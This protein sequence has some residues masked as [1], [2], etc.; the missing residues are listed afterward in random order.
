MDET[1]LSGVCVSTSDVSNIATNEGWTISSSNRLR[2][3]FFVY[4]VTLPIT[5]TKSF[6]ANATIAANYET[7]KGITSISAVELQQDRERSPQ[8][9]NAVFF[10]GDTELVNVATFRINGRIYSAGNLMVGASKS[11]PITFYQV[12]SSGGDTTDPTAITTNPDLFGSCYYEKQNSEIAVAGNVVEG[13]AVS[14]DPAT[15]S[16]DDTGKVYAHLFRGAGV[17][18]NTTTNTIAGG[19]AE[20][21]D[22]GDS[23]TSTV[24]VNSSIGVGT[25]YNNR[26]SGLSL[27]DFEYNRRLGALVDEAVSR[28]TLTISSYPPATVNSLTYSG[29]GD[30][31][32]VRD[33][34]FKR[35][36]DEALSSIEEVIVARRAAFTA[37]FGERIRRVSF[38]EVPF[39][40]ST[41]TA[42][43]SPLLT[44]VPVSGQPDELAPPIA[45]MLPSYA[46]TNFGTA[47]GGFSISAKT[48]FEARG[49]IFDATGGVTLLTAG[50]PNRLG[51]SAADFT[52][53]AKNN[54]KFLG[55]R[56]LVGNGLPAQW[57]KKD[58][59]GSLVFVGANV[60]HYISTQTSSIFWNDGNDT[61]GATVSSSERYRYTQATSLSSLGVSDRGGF[62]ELSAAIDPAAS[63]IKNTG[64]LRVVTNA[65]IYSRQSSDTFLPRFV[66]GVPNSSSTTWDDSSAPLYNGQPIDNPLT[67]IN[68]TNFAGA[69]DANYLVWSD[70]MPMS[71]NTRWLDSFSSPSRTTAGYYYPITG[72]DGWSPSVDNRKGDLQMRATAIYHYKYDAFDPINSPTNYQQ[73]IACVSSY[74]DPSTSITA[75]NGSIPNGSSGSV[76]SPWNYDV[77]GRSNNGLVYAV[78][79]NASSTDV[80]FGSITY[81][82]TTGLFGDFA[83]G[84]KNPK[85]ATIGYGDRLAYQANLMFPNGRFANEPLREVLKKIKTKGAANPAAA[86]LTLPQQATIDSNLCALQILDGSLALANTT[87]TS[88]ALSPIPT[89]PTGITPLT[90]VQIPHGS[91]RESAFL[92]GREVKSLNRNES[93]TEGAVGNNSRAA[94]GNGLAIPVVNRGDIYDLQIEQRQPLE[95]RATDIDMDRLRGSKLEGG[96]NATLATDY[97]L[98]YSGIIYATREDALEDLS[99]NKPKTAIDATTCPPVTAGNLCTTVSDADRKNLSSTDFLLDPTRKP[100]S[101]R[102]V[103]GYRLWRSALISANLPN[104]DGLTGFGTTSSAGAATAQVS[105]Y[106][107]TNAAYR[108]SSATQDEKGLTLVSN[109]PVYVKVQRDPKS[110]TAV[111]AFNKHTRE[112]FTQLL[113]DD[114]SNFYTRHANNGTND[115]L[116]PN[117][118]CRPYQ[119]T[120]CLLGDEWRPATVLADAVTVLSSNFRDGYRTDGDFDLRNNS[121]TSTSIN[122]QSQLSETATADNTDKL[123]DSSYVLEMR[124]QGFF[125]NNFVTSNPWQQRVNSNNFAV[126]D[127][128]LWPGDPGNAT[129]VNNGNLASYNANGVTPVQR[130]INFNEYGM[131]MCRKFP[132][133][134]CT[135]SD[136]VKDNAGTTT[137]PNFTS[138]GVI[139][140]AVTFVGS[141][142]YI[143]PEN[144]RYPRR[145]SFLRFDDIYK[146]GNQQIIFSGSC[147]NT[148]TA[149]RLFASVSPIV[150]GIGN[151]NNATDGYTYPYV[152]GNFATPFSTTTTGNNDDNTNNS[153]GTVP[154]PERGIT[155]GITTGDQDIVEGRRRD[156]N[157]G[158]SLEKQINS[159][160]L[161]TPEANWVATTNANA[162]SGRR[163]DI[164]STDGYFTTGTVTDSDDSGTPS[165]RN[166][167]YRRFN[168]T[169]GISN[170]ASLAAGETVRVKVTLFARNDTGAF[171]GSA[172][173]STTE[174]TT[175]P[176]FTTPITESNPNTNTNTFT[177]AGSSYVNGDFIKITNS[178]TAPQLIGGTIPGDYYVVNASGTTF[179]VA[180]TLGGAALDIINSGSGTFTAQRNPTTTT[181]PTT[182]STVPTPFPPLYTITSRDAS[183]PNDRLTVAHS[184]YRNGDRVRITNFGSISGDYFVLNVSTSGTNQ[185]FQ[186]AATSGGSR[187]DLTTT[188]SSVSATSRVQQLA[189]AS[190][191]ITISGTTVNITTN[192]FTVAGS[193][194]ANGDLINITTSATAPTY[195]VGT[196][197]VNVGG[198]YYVVNASGTNFQI[199]A[200][201]GGTALDINTTGSGT[202]T[203]QQLAYAKNSITQ[204]SVNATANTFTL[205]SSTSY[206]NGAYINIATL[207]TAPTTTGAVPI[208]GDY[209][210]VNPTGSPSGNTFQIAAT[211]GGTALDITNSGLGTITFQQHPIAVTTAG[212]ITIPVNYPAYPIAIT[213]S[214]PNTNTNT[215]TVAGTSYASGDYIGISTVGTSPES[216]SGIISGNYYVV[217]PSGTTFQ[218]ATTS[219]GTPLDITNSGSGTLTVQR[220]PTSITTASSAS[221]AF[222]YSEYKFDASTITIS[223]TSTLN[224]AGSNYT[225]G[226]YVTITSVDGGTLPAA[227]PPA[228]YIVINASGTTFQLATTVAPTIPIAIA[229]QGTGTFTIQQKARPYSFSGAANNER[230]TITGGHNFAIGQSVML[231][232]L[233]ST[234]AGL[235][236]NTT[237]YI[238][239]AVSA[240]EF[241]LS[242]N[243]DLS[244]EVQITSNLTGTVTALQADLIAGLY[245]G[246]PVDLTIARKD[247]TTITVPMGGL[248]PRNTAYGAVSAQ[249][250]DP[251]DAACPTSPSNN[252]CTV[253]SWI[254]PTATTNDPD[255]KVVTVLVARDSFAES[256][257]EEFRLSLDNLFPIT[258]TN[259]TY[260]AGRAGFS[261][262]TAGRNASLRRGRIRTTAN[263]NISS[264]GCTPGTL[265]TESDD[266]APVICQTPTPVPTATPT[267]PPATPT[268]VPTPTPEPPTETSNPP[269]VFASLPHSSAMP[270]S[271]MFRPAAAYPFRHIANND[272]LWRPFSP[273]SAPIDPSVSPDDGRYVWGNDLNGDRIQNTGE[274]LDTFPDIPPRSAANGEIPMLPGRF[275]RPLD[276]TNT[277]STPQMMDRTAPSTAD[278][279][280]W[281]RTKTSNSDYLGRSDRIRYSV[282]RNL[283]INNLSFPVNSDS[284]ANL[285][286]SGR[287]VLPPTPCL[288]DTTGIVDDRCITKSYTFGSNTPV[289]AGTDTL[290]NL[291]LPYN[292]YFPSDS[293]GTATNNNFDTTAEPASSFTVCGATGR[294][295]KYQAIERPTLS[296]Y[297]ISGG[298]VNAIV[299]TA[300]TSCPL[301]A[302]TPGE[303]IKNFVGSLPGAVTTNGSGILSSTFDPT[304]ATLF[305]GMPLVAA[306]TSGTLTA[307]FTAAT[308]SASGTTAPVP[309]TINAVLRAQNTFAD[310]RVHVY[311]VGNLGSSENGLRTLNGTLTFRANCIDPVTGADSTCTPTSLRKGP[312][313]VFIMRGLPGESIE[314]SGLKMV[315][316]GVDPNN[317]F[318]VS[319]RTQ[320]RI[321][322]KAPGSAGT[323]Q[324]FLTNNGNV[325]SKNADDPSIS[326]GKRIIISSNP[327][328]PPPL[329]AGN[330]YYISG[331]NGIGSAARLTLS[332]L[333]PPKP[334]PPTSGANDCADNNPSATC[335]PIAKVDGAGAVS[336]ATLPSFI[337]SGG[338]PGSP[339]AITGATTPNIIT[340]NFLGY[341]TATGTAALT[342]DNTSVVSTLDQYTSFRGV[343]FLGLWGDR[344][345]LNTQTLLT[346]MTTV[347]QPELLP[348]LQLNVP[349][350]ATNNQD[351]IA[352]PDLS[353]VSGTT[354]KPTTGNS[355]REG[356]W[357]IR[358]AK[359]EVNVYF[360]AG[361]TPSRNGVGYTTSSTFFDGP[362]DSSAATTAETG[363]GLANFVRFLENWENIPLK[364][365]GGFIQNTKSRYATAPFLPM[366]LISRKSDITTLFLNPVLPGSGTVNGSNSSGFSLTYMSSTGSSIPYYFPPIRLWGYDVGLLTQQPDRFAERFAQPIAGS[367][368]FFREVSADDT[369]VE[370]LLCSLEP[371]DPVTN[372]TG[373]APSLYTKRALR[374]NDLRSACNS[375][376][377]GGATATDGTIG[378][379]VYE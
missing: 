46:N 159:F 247:G 363:G 361:S 277:T 114:W 56:I 27:N 29:T 144:F 89:A 254:G 231:S 19:V 262:P 328:P 69:G 253:L 162:N 349:N 251:Q 180:T 63:G 345:K 352:Q 194:Y 90:S 208:S 279:T 210:V 24:S 203:T 271:T 7:Y 378:N 213:Q 72:G 269:P 115:K 45:W 60:P 323:L 132:I 367:N 267:P 87:A 359:A 317:I 289:V 65:G 33:D 167:V 58:S 182:T 55:D 124:K 99:Y 195:L 140:T 335:P 9:N 282:N 270:F 43:A 83:A 196:T 38:R 98:P 153:Y 15:L 351:A 301:G 85:D 73:P 102:L 340:G 342:E 268:P 234:T 215:I 245:N 358:P 4:A 350:S 158:G 121:N 117:F 100:S 139:D 354:G 230:L 31:T 193:S 212:T 312:S 25:Q 57:L 322:L 304:N 77:K 240:T 336:L 82:S 18:P 291:N 16:V 136:W 198:N 78:G 21:T 294:T 92:N 101:I 332:T 243:A 26:S 151:G 113:L 326:V 178:G 275:N 3:S 225:N 34:L 48:G 258:N 214:N 205:P 371:A 71:G 133:S 120:T 339:N 330:T 216:T 320:S 226:S 318:W 75:K 197:N 252:Y 30:P 95:I 338:I 235:S 186:I 111:P 239:N 246:S 287:L 41:P 187:V 331:I 303:A 5:D 292:P 12:S 370:A 17:P 329:V 343:R 308:Y 307:T 207:G 105:D 284:R 161:P 191:P 32:S 172:G 227:L 242:A 94:S 143:A 347:N 276:T 199:A 201:P 219:G 146:D 200:I 84:A 297:D 372:K 366:Q 130:R 50:A 107:Y 257:D 315:L 79:K 184:R 76:N 341:T 183:N 131:E 154:C 238:K 369:W 70:S 181:T 280:L 218:I 356:Q 324:D 185:T 305:K 232:G 375:P 14:D 228:D 23:T 202:F 321:E 175:Y 229:T 109:L 51:L 119:T 150:L 266:L 337:F 244:D 22:T 222:P 346:A 160:V 353:L 220:Q 233:S 49:G 285:Y 88:A 171:A 8:N 223:P 173:A 164:A 362:T 189:F 248:F 10:E 67:S 327:T 168:Y 106:D 264:N 355:S 221:D 96:N 204:T 310:N 364:I 256:P 47:I 293:T 319:S 261:S 211:A 52:E 123:K 360:V 263:S 40:T 379:D 368:E 148:P 192:T 241:N 35:I 91:F 61:S 20:I 68:E 288:N 142:R 37:Y 206:R 2:K 156:R 357:T 152:M 126:T 236:T 138:A 224:V 28:S 125:N 260:M 374:G 283:F 80:S 134:E 13:D 300:T 135:F 237:Y 376:V 147:E 166:S 170:R 250:V 177:V 141:P 97:L 333:P 104:I 272:I 169:V 273:P 295:H 325:G 112:E 11:N 165:A 348:V 311:S 298:I 157:T 116:D 103:N 179:Q 53:V 365:T 278:R 122:W 59:S 259:L 176:A 118:A 265:V 163:L 74:Y 296:K 377:Y 145:V 217:N 309:P 155:V 281:Y 290:L 334:Y 249:T 149:S 314:F 64:G 302:S 306:S 6:P 62:W 44:P 129:T 274:S 190:Y 286:S 128:A 54:E 108:W 174:T 81:N 373:G 299:P 127:S 36:Q 1:T 313:P 209:Y 255:N 66:T 110:A 86:G 93:L 39:I 137:L 188:N 42:F 344:S 316:D